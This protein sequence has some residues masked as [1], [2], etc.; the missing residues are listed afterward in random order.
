MQIGLVFRRRQGGTHV[1]CAVPL[2]S[3]T[4]S[5][6]KDAEKNSQGAILQSE[7]LSLSRKRSWPNS[8]KNGQ[9]WMQY[10]RVRSRTKPQMD[11]QSVEIAPLWLLAMNQRRARL[12]SRIARISR[13]P[14]RSFE[15]GK[16]ILAKIS[17]RLW[18]KMS[19]QNKATYFATNK[20]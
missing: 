15:A 13:T 20:G 19:R 11:A 10:F 3:R 6:C 9:H 5:V 16:G 1:M 2:K 12:L 8:A 14:M 4:S 18:W 7:T 17:A